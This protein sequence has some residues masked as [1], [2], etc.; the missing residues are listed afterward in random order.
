MA[1]R[2]EG[3]FDVFDVPD[4]AAPRDF[5]LDDFEDDFDFAFGCEDDFGFDCEDF[6]F[7]VD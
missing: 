3:D 6:D 4:F 2:A 7:D 5:A 1:F